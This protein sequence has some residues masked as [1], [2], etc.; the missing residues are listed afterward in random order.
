[1][2]CA[3]GIGAHHMDALVVQVVVRKNIKKIT[4]DDLMVSV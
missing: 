2:R 3:R 4:K 1:M